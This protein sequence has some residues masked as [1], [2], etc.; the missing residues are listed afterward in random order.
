MTGRP[1]RGIEEWR[2]QLG[3]GAAHGGGR[4]VRPTARY[5]A[6]GWRDVIEPRILAPRAVERGVLGRN[7]W[8]TN[9]ALLYERFL[10]NGRF[11]QGQQVVDLN[12]SHLV[13]LLKGWSVTYFGAQRPARKVLDALREEACAA[14]AG[15]CATWGS[16]QLTL[17]CIEPLAIGLGNPSGLDFGL[18]LEPLS[19][20]PYI[21]GSTL[22]GCARAAALE[23]LAERFGIPYPT[24]KGGSE[25][26]AM[27]RALATFEDLLCWEPA[28]P[29]AGTDA[30]SSS[31]RELKRILKNLADA[32][33][34]AGSD[35][36]AGWERFEAYDIT[37]WERIAGGDA[38]VDASAPL[39][40]A[41]RLAFGSTGARGEVMFSDALPQGFA[42]FGVELVTPHYTPYYE[43]SEPAADW[44][45]PVPV[46][47][48]VVPRQTQFECVLGSWLPSDLASAAAVRAQAAAWLESGLSWGIGG[49]RAV[50][51][52]GMRVMERVESAPEQDEGEQ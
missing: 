40:R 50:Q 13:P 25:D 18:S 49:R 14:V 31:E 27:S 16:T 45:D 1:V 33:L 15:V 39:V 5:P 51:H 23:D 26:C 21:P 32:L 22:K 52:G 30:R 35:G 41:F 10:P 7:P 2:Q 46:T 48:L 38:T 47:Y 20:G 12:P 9:F 24:G 3:E 44:H 36:E 37:G 8:E 34:D 28:P 11:R 29:G 43:G 17:R 6:D 19:G 42:G 4:A